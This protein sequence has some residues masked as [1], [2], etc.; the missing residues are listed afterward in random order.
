MNILKGLQPNTVMKN[1]DD[2]IEG[3]KL[4]GINGGVLAF[5]SMAEILDFLRV[6][7]L[8]VSIAWTVAKLWKLI[9]E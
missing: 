7:L 4:W 9:N 2:I 3:L 6:I 1:S 5:A 8:L